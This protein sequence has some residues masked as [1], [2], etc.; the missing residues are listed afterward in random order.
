MYMCIS[1]NNRFSNY[2]YHDYTCINGC[3]LK[4]GSTGIQA[5]MGVNV[6]EE[7]EAYRV[8]FS[9]WVYYREYFTMLLCSPIEEAL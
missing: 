6:C 5:C 2:P 3:A 7:M 8:G 4:R 9:G 1:P